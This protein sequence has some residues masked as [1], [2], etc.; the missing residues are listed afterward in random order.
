MKH[1]ILCSTIENND[2]ETLS[3]PNWNLKY[4]NISVEENLSDESDIPE[5]EKAND[6]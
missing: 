5:N 1:I 2:G 3:A 6:S 4:G